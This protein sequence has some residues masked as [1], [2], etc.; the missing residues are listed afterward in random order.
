MWW[1]F[2][3]ILTITKGQYHCPDDS[4]WNSCAI[5]R[6]DS[7]WWENCKIPSNIKSGYISHGLN[8]GFT[9]HPFTNTGSG[10]LSVE[11]NYKL[12]QFDTRYNRGCCFIGLDSVKSEFVSKTGSYYYSLSD[13]CSYHNLWS[14]QHFSR[15]GVGGKY[16]YKAFEYRTNT[17]CDTYIG[18]IWGGGLPRV[19]SLAWSIAPS[20]PK[21]NTFTFCGYDNGVCT[22]LIT[23]V[24]YWLKYG[25]GN[26][27]GSYNYQF[28]VPTK[29][30]TLPCNGN[31]FRSNVISGDKYCYRSNPIFEFS[32]NLGLW[33]PVHVCGGCSISYEMSYGVSQ[34]TQMG[35]SNTWAVSLETSVK[36]SAGFSKGPISASVET[37]MTAGVSNQ[38]TTTQVQSFDK[39]EEQKMKLA[40]TGTDKEAMWQY[41]TK[42]TENSIHG[43]KAFTVKSRTYWC[44]TDDRLSPQCP[45]GYCVGVNCQSCSSGTFQDTIPEPEKPPATINVKTRDPKV[46]YFNLDE[47]WLLAS[48]VLIF[49]VLF[50]NL[51]FCVYK[52]CYKYR[53]QT[54][55]YKKVSVLS[56]TE[57]DAIL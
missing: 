46:Y 51:L 36:G 42:S 8:G 15:F 53:Q 16:L 1:L 5:D 21:P 52:S 33:N 6:V 17:R 57:N 18:G 14:G 41:M 19:T 39:K 55:Q 27:G 12:S 20:F 26:D 35:K 23:G 40:C 22:G 37:T 7:G 28:V 10:D 25:N 38:V 29:G 44:T 47:W 43:M 30:T 13:T 50:A 56:D 32:A 4:K 45:P 54:V 2:F 24:A 31:F 49:V 11:C 9:L 3:A 48:G 34:G